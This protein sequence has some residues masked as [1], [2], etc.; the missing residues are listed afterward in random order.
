MLCGA[1]DSTV[2][3]YRYQAAGLSGITVVSTGTWIVALSDAADLDALDEARGMTCNADPAGRPL[4]GVLCMGGREFFLIAGA[5]PAGA[6]GDAAV[7]ARLVAR[8]TLPLPFFGEDDGLLPGRAGRG[9]ILGPPPA[10][11][12]ERR[13][14]ALIATALLTDLLLDA[15]GRTG[16]VVLDGSFTGDPLYP[17]LVAALRPGDDV[18]FNRHSDGVAAGAALLAGHTRAHRA[19]DAGARPSGPAGHSRPRRLPRP[20]AR[21]DRVR[22]EE[23]LMAKTDEAALRREMVQ[24]ARRMN[25]SGINQGTSGNL[26]V[27]C[28]GGFLITPSSLPY[29]AMKPAD[30]MK[31]GFDGTYEGRHRPS[32]EWRFHRD[33]L[34]EREDVNVVLHCHSVFATTLAVS[35]QADPGVPL[36]GRRRR[37]QHDPLRPLRHLRHPG[38]VGRGDRGA[39]RAAAPAC[40]ASTGRSRSARRSPARCGWR[41]RWRRW[42]ACTCRRCRSASRRCCRRRRWR[43]CWSRCGA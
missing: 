6:L 40:S 11:A 1:H 43:A 7:A 14:L 32:S 21:T 24:T 28:E 41:S 31:M 38:P 8:G 13:A 29:E 19:G 27:R 39:G 4:A 25:A 35:S 16:R 5:Q 3:F 18:A 30:I 42:R 12:A 26:S 37:R 20:L 22:H 36:H 23:L 17:A 2:N 15:L 34:R 9:A 33:I 10:D